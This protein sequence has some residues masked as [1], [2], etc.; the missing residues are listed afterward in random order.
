MNINEKLYCVK[1]IDRSADHD[2]VPELVSGIWDDWSSWEDREGGANMV[3]LYA[4]E[5]EK[6]GELLQDMEKFRMEW[7]ELGAELDAPE[8]FELAR[9][10]WSEVWKKYFHVIEVAPNLA[11]KPSLLNAS[12]FQQRQIDQTPYS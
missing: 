2:L 10:D 6:A 11:I 4:Q 7:Q 9:E 1:L 5:P 12:I 3:V 8:Y